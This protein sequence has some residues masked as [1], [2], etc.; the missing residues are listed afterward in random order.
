MR[1]HDEETAADVSDEDGEHDDSFSPRDLVHKQKRTVPKSAYVILGA[2]VRPL[3]RL[4]LACNCNLQALIRT[5][6]CV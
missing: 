2:A 4:H 1:R 3:L 5:C 6:F